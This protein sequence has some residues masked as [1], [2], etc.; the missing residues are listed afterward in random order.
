MPTNK[1]FKRLV[2]GRMQKTGESYTAA[3][4]HLLQTPRQSHSSPRPQPAAYATLAG[5]SDATIKAKTGCTWERWVQALDRVQAHTW[6]HREIARHVSARYKTPAWWAQMVTVGYERI[7]G[8]REIGQR[9]GGFFEARKSKTVA[10]P[11]RRL[12]RAFRDPRTRARWLPGVDMKIRRATPSKSARVTWNDG[13]S[14]EAYFAPKG[15][16]KSQ[17]VVQH[18]PLPTRQ[19][20]AQ[21]KRYWAERLDVLIA[22]LTDP[23]GGR[24]A[25]VAR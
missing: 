5:M 24:S 9:R 17:V 18:G 6:P 13:T 21:M 16:A 14:L 8:L 2:R 3:R 22:L 19:V 1:D 25:P 7:R 12:Y 10:V 23:G 15:A 4:A 20:A 11:V